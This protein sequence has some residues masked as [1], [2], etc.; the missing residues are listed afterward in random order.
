MSTILNTLKVAKVTSFLASADIAKGVLFPNV[1]RTEPRYPLMITTERIII[2]KIFNKDPNY[3]NLKICADY[4]YDLC[5]RY[6]FAA[7]AIV[8]GGGGGS[9]TP[10]TQPAIFPLYITQAAFTT[11]TFYPNVKLFG[12]NIIV[13][14]N[15]INR[16]LLPLTEFSYNSL[17]LTILID[18]FDA[19]VNSYN[20]VIEKYTN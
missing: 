11:A 4:L 20:L 3:T 1:I 7:Q 9:I 12:N 19:S 5:G 13:Y 6:R 15:E 8:D 18:G 2:E 16:Y 17:G 10:V 14:L